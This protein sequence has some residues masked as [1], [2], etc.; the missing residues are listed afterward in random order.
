MRY[1]LRTGLAV[2]TLA[3]SVIIPSAAFAATS[4]GARTASAADQCTVV[5]TDGFGAGLGIRMTMSP[6]GP[7]VAFFDEADGSPVTGLG[8]LNR[9]HPALGRDAGIEAEILNPYGSTPQLLAKT[10]GGRSGYYNIQNF[11]TLPKGCSLDEGTVIKQCTVSHQDGIGAGLDAR[12]TMSPKGPS[13][14]FIDEADGSQVTRLGTL[15]R[16]R[17]K[18]PDSAGIYAEIVQPTSWDPQ[19]KS[20]TQGGSTPYAF[21]SFPKLPKGCPLN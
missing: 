15:N 13:V 14:T 20:K 8:P 9:S 16:S 1:T 10:N 7:S 21:T 2:A 11:P 6:Q 3:G 12:L 4:H 19:L 17:P 5:K 18:L